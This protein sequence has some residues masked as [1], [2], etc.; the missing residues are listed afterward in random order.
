MPDISD[1]KCICGLLSLLFLWVT[2]L[3]GLGVYLTAAYVLKR[4]E[5]QRTSPPWWAGL[6]ERLARGALQI[7]LPKLEL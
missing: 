3:F 6:A 4:D 5:V 1:T 2:T 7:T